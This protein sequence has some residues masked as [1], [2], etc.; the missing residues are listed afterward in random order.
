VLDI[1]MYPP[2]RNWRFCH[3]LAHILLGHTE[4]DVINEENEREAD[5]LA[6]ELL[7]PKDEF[8]RAMRETGVDG[9]KERFPYASWEVIARRWA[10]ERPAV[11]TIYDNGRLTGRYGPGELKF[12]PRPSAAEVELIRKCYTEKKHLAESTGGGVGLD[13][14]AL[15]V[16]DGRGVERVLLLTEPVSDSGLF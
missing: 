8:R 1:D 6:A 13:M 9:L 5:K 10:S 11:L 4:V 14:H 7:I 16:D 3:E 15:F 2:R 12:P